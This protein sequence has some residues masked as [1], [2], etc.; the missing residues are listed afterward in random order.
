MAEV[1]PGAPS[2]EPNNARYDSDPTRP[3]RRNDPL[4]GRG[5]NEPSRNGNPY[6]DDAPDGENVTV[7]V[8]ADAGAKS[9]DGRENYSELRTQLDSERAKRLELE[10]LAQ[11]QL[12]QTQR[13]EIESGYREAYAARES[14]IAEAAKAAADY[15]H[16]KAAR[17]TA[18]AA[19]LSSKLLVF[20]DG[21]NAAEQALRQ[22]QQPVGEHQRRQQYLN[23]QSSTN[24]KLIEQAGDRFWTDEP[25]RN[26]A[27]AASSYLVNRGYKSDGSDPRYERE[28]RRM[29]NT[30]ERSR[31]GARYAAPPTNANVTSYGYQ[32][33]GG[34]T[35]VSLSP[36]EREL[37]RAWFT[38]PEYRGVDPE[39]HYAKFKAACIKDG[40]IGGG[41]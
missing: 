21:K 31:E 20:E 30:S 29:M 34:E 11:R 12:L 2:R 39:L 28:M 23:Q 26:A 10:R 5:I 25:Y 33:R 40:Q 17:A 13:A 22:Q 15:D 18:D 41:S 9:N 37:A 36:K 16:E 6:H 35:V 4:T 14:K 7:V 27:I 19:Y 38:G 8:D 1:L 32:A 24:R 3:T